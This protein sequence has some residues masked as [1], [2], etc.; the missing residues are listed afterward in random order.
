MVLDESPEITV[1]E[2]PAFRNEHNSVDF[3]DK[4]PYSRTRW[5]N[6]GHCHFGTS[7]VVKLR[8]ATE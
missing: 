4:S 1:K 7:I 2:I 8:S 5:L 6:E 3:Y